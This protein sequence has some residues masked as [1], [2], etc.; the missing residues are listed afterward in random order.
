[1]LSSQAVAQTLSIPKGRTMLLTGGG[2]GQD[3]LPAPQG[4][5]VALEATIFNQKGPVRVDV[6]DT[7]GSTLRGF[8]LGRRGEATVY[9]GPRERLFIAATQGNA[10]VKVTYVAAPEPS[11]A[12]PANETLSFTLR[13]PGA[14]PI[15]LEIPGVMNP[16]LSPFSNS[17]VSLAPGQPIY[18]TPNKKKGKRILIYRVPEDLAPGTVLDV[19]QLVSDAR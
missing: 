17:G 4:S 19:A 15:P 9:V 13:N 16:N 7:G 12:A 18:W 2:P 6:R 8:G 10:K 11:N 5:E 14:T 1:M 3:G